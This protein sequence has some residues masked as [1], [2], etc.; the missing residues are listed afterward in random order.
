MRL[1]GKVA[2]ITGAS[3]GIGEAC[4]RAFRARG[5]RIALTARNESKLRGAAGENDF[6][7]S[8]DLTR[9]EDR[10]RVVAETLAHFGRVDILVNN[11]G[12]GVYAPAHEAP[13]DQTRHL[14]E[15]NFFAPLRMT[16]LVAPIMRRQ[17][18][19][20]VV[21]IS[22]IAGKVTL[23]WFTLYSAS[24]YALCSL[25]DGLRMELRRSGIHVMKVCP[26]YVD[27][28]FQAHVLAGKSPAG[29]GGTRRTFA[30]TADE[31]AAAIARGIEREA[32]TVLTPRSGWLF[33]L[34]ERL[35]PGLVDAQLERIYY[36]S[37]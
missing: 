12:I 37:R 25:S 16:Q 4:A 21:N 1:A 19:G 35:F 5:S 18:A 28:Q 17:Q 11:A 8:G 29:V 7:V 10:Q 31:C 26:G 33:V 3:E 34:A 15:L 20:V 24:K 30:I 14:F 13:M 9:E 22:S 36:A 27:T 6:V 2:L 23:P 32:R